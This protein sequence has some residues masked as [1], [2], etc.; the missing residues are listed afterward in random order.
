M[1]EDRLLLLLAF[2]A[3][4]I[5]VLAT[6][7]TYSSIVGIVDRITGYQTGEANLTIA[8]QAEINFTTR[9]ISWGSGKV[10]SGSTSAAL[11]T[12]ST[13]NVTGGNWTLT[14][15]GGL[16]IV[17]I[18]NVNVTLNLSVGKTHDSF[19]GG[20]SPVYR[21][22]LSAVEANS[23]INI[24]GGTGFSPRMNSFFNASP[25]AV[26]NIFCDRFRYEAA[27]DVIRID[28]NLTIPEDAVTGAR[29]DVITATAT[30]V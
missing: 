27:N 2:A 19:I 29:G 24:T 23:C 20:T 18:G 25:A 15:S 4:F 11:T 13:N 22:N 28:F 5:A 3:F 9:A 1:K 21:W 30:T 14:T 26:D 6:I 16:R 12:F 7:L 17:N 10:S 8:T